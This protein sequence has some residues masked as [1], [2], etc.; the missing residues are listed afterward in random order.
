M[1][2]YSQ[3]E[4]SIDTD[5]DMLPCT[6]EPSSKSGDRNYCMEE[7]PDSGKWHTRRNRMCVLP[8]HSQICHPEQHPQI[9]Y[10]IP[11]LGIMKLLFTDLL[12]MILL[13]ENNTVINITV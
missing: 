3:E 7:E 8:C 1:D 5:S 13:Q 12:M 11:S 6:Q 9:M 10:V 4:I 2:K